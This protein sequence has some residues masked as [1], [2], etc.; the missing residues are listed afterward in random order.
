MQEMIKCPLCGARTTC[1]LGS[2]APVRCESCRATFH[3]G[4]GRKRLTRG[5]S[6]RSKSVAAVLALILGT[7]GAHRFYLGQPLIGLIYLIF[8]WTW[9]PTIIGIIEAVIFASMDDDLFSDQY[10]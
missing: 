1:K 3:A 7:V 2:D 4:M 10:A 8:C 5:S 9:I 6:N